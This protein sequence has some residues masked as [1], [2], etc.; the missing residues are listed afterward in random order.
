M[1]G[2]TLAKPYDTKIRG[3]M[4]IM[5]AKF[6]ALVACC[7]VPYMP[8]ARC[9]SQILSMKLQPWLDHVFQATMKLQFT[10]TGIVFSARSQHLWLQK[11]MSRAVVQASGES[12]RKNSGVWYPFMGLIAP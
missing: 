6:P 7:Q 9:S 5:F 12:W 1:D 10:M 3:N 2:C 11:K 8:Q 4:S